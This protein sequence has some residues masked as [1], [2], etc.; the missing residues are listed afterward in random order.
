MKS[1]KTIKIKCIIQDIFTQKEK[2]FKKQEI[3]S[4]L[5][6]ILVTSE[7]NGGQFDE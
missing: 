1:S 4:I 2:L 6:W 7:K 5:F 3:M